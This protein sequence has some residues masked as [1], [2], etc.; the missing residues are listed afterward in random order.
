MT[1]QINIKK[2]HP[3]RLDALNGTKL[4]D[5]DESHILKPLLTPV[6]RRVVR[7]YKGF[8]CCCCC[9]Y[10]QRLTECKT[11]KRLLYKWIYLSRKC[12]NFTLLSKKMFRINFYV[13]KDKIIKFSLVFVLFFVTKYI[14]KCI[15]TIL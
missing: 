3:S 11:G 8:F 14:Y 15:I 9:C 2:G 6:E 4:L 7:Y 13:I 5:R 12:R 10:K 1:G